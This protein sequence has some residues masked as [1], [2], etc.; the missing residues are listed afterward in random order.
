M[1]KKLQVGD[2]VKVVQ[3]TKAPGDNSFEYSNYT[4][5]LGMV[6]TIDS[7]TD[8]DDQYPIHIEELAVVWRHEDFE[9]VVNKVLIGGKLC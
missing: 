5:H 1:A 3:V 7:I 8:D 4:H 2:R 9:L 6:Y